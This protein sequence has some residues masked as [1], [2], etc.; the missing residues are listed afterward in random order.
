MAPQ[1]HTVGAVSD[2]ILSTFASA[3]ER[4][5][6][7]TPDAREQILR[8]LLE[9]MGK[10]FVGIETVATALRLAVDD[11]SDLEYVRN[12]AELLAAARTAVAVTET[13][14]AMAKS[15][16][17]PQSAYAAV[18]ERAYAVR[19]ALDWQPGDYAKSPEFIRLLDEA[20]E[21]H[22]AGLTV[23]G[24]FGER[25]TGGV[26]SGARSARGCHIIYV[27]WQTRPWS[28]STGARL[29]HPYGPP[30]W[31]TAIV[32]APVLKSRST[33]TIAPWPTSTGTPT[34]GSGST[35]TTTST[36]S[37]GSEVTRI[38]A[39][40]M[41]AGRGEMRCPAHRP[42]TT[43]PVNSHRAISKCRWLPTRTPTAA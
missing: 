35:R 32:D 25:T 33:W 2:Q 1:L 19:R 22:E 31:D 27:R 30:R 36:G 8:T 38:A 40:P 21:E 12:E 29:I 9:T 11:L 10:A 24:G 6:A 16:G 42:A 37:S 26:G 4:F 23:E 3:H 13:V 28:C 14:V 41:R 39:A 15:M 5:S 43:I 7:P 34:S 20:I 17:L 18:E